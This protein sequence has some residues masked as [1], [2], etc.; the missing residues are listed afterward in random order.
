MQIAATMA[1]LM[2]MATGRNTSN[3]RPH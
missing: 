1:P 3:R 2:T